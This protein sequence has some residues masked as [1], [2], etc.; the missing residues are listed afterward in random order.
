MSSY[1]YK[2]TGIPVE[3][4]QG[5]DGETAGDG[6]HAWGVGVGPQRE[7]DPATL[8]TEERG[9]ARTS[10]GVVWVDVCDGELRAI[11]TTIGA[12][13]DNDRG[14]GAVAAT[15]PWSQGNRGR[16]SRPPGFVRVAA[17]RAWP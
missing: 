5:R 1:Q 15:R 13:V 12:R 8:P 11:P 7:V 4:F 9:P 10:D 6:M 17:S 3:Q 2:C 14:T 16:D